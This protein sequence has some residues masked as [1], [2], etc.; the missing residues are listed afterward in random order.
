MR[1]TDQNAQTTRQICLIRTDVLKWRLLSHVWLFS[2]LY[3]VHGIL[4]VRIL[5]WGA[6]PFSRGSFQP[7]ARTLVSHIAGGFFTSWAT[8]EAQNVLKDR[9]IC[10]FIKHPRWCLCQLKLRTL[11]RLIKNADDF[12]PVE[13]QQRQQGLEHPVVQA[14]HLFF[15][16]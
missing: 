1:A 5:E 3:M 8:R 15:F 12:R 9:V 4:Q 13:R 10:I 6:F 7:R 16:P 2:T 14:L 11:E